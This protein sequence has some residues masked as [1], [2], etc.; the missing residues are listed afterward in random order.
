MSIEG[1]TDLVSSLDDAARAL[2]ANQAAH[3]AAGRLLVAKAEPRTPRR[4]GT[5]AAGV[6]YDA[7]DGVTVLADD[8]RYAPFVHA[9]QPWLAETIDDQVTPVV[10]IFRDEVEQIVH[11]IHT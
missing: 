10:E 4:T 11:T 8:V 9:A 3:D 7:A 5:L 2:E 1:I 6:R